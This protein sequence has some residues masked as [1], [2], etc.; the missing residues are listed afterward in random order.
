MMKRFYLVLISIF[1]FI[2]SLF[3]FNLRKVALE[4]VGSAVNS[5]FQ[6]SR[7]LV[8]IASNNGLS[9]YDGK[10]V[11]LIGGY[12]G[13]ENIYGNSEG[14]IFAETVYGLRVIN[15]RSNTVTP[16][17]MFNNV[18]FSAVDTK[19]TSFIIQGNTSMYYKYQAGKNY[20]NITI[21]GLNSMRIKLFFVDKIG[22]LRILSE[23]GILRSFELSYNSN[24]IDFEEKRAI[25]LPSR[26]TFS[27]TDEQ[28]LYFIDEKFG[29]SRFDFESNHSSYISDMKPL[30]AD[31]GKITSGIVFKN[32]FYFGTESGLFQIKNNNLVTI[33]VKAGVSRLVKDRYQDLIWI[34]TMGDGLYTYSS[35]PLTIKSYLFSDFYPKVSKAATAICL[36]KQGTLWIGTEGAGIV[37][38]PDFHPEREISEINILTKENGLPDNNVY[39]FHESSQGIWIGCESGLAFFS[40]KN[41]HVSSFDN[42]LLTDIQS[43][44]ENDSLLWMACYE[45]GIVKANITYRD[46]KPEIR[47]TQLYS[48]GNQDEASNRFTSIYADHRNILFTNTG[49]GIYKFVD[50]KL[51][52]IGLK[53][54]K[55]ESANQI[56]S[57][58]ESEY[59][60][61]TD[62]GCYKFV[63][64][65]KTIRNIQAL[66]EVATKDILPGN[67]GDY[68]LS[69]DN[70]L[71]LYNIAQN[72]IQYFSNSYGLTVSDYCNG[73]SFKDMQSGMLFFGGMNGFVVIQYNYYDE[74]MDYMPLLALEK[75]SLFGIYQNI[76]DFKRENSDKLVFEAEENVFSLTFNAIDY[77]NGNNYIYYYKIAD[78]QWIDN[79]NSGTISFTDISSG[80]YELYIKYYNKMLN[81]ESYTHMLTMTVLPPWYRSVY[82]YIAYFLL[83]LFSV[84]LSMHFILK[85]RRKKR[86]DEL[87]RAEQ[88]RVEDIYEAKLDF[89][90]D[91]A[92]EFCTPLTLISGPCSLILNQKGIAAPVQKYA[93][94]INRNAK[95]MNLLINDLMAFKQ[96]ESGFKLPEISRL[97]VSSILD[98]IVDAFK[99]NALGESIH[100]EK[101]YDEA[102]IWNSDEEFL[103][104]ILT[105]LISNAVKYSNDGS[106]SVEI[107]VENDVLVITVSN[108]GKGIAQEELGNI[109]NRFSILTS[110]KQKGWKQNGLG[111]AITGSMVRLLSGHI[112]VFS[113][114]NENTSFLVNLP[115]MEAKGIV[116]HRKNIKNDHDE[117]IIPEVVIPLAKYEHNENRATVTIIDDDP[118]MLWFICDTL[119]DEFNVLPVNDAS[120]ATG[121]LSQ[122]HTD[123]IVS[124]LMMG[125]MDGVELAKMLKSDKSTSHIPLIIVSAMHEIEMQTEVINAGAEMYI[126]KPFDPKNLKTT[127]RRL[128]GRKEDLK[129]YFTSPLSA[130]ELEMGKMQHGEHRK[131]LKKVYLIIS[132][133]IQNENLSPQFIASELG[134]SRRTLYRKVKEVTDKGLLE[135]IR[136]GRLTT[137]EN[138][139]LTSKSTIDEIVFKSGFSSR[140]SFYRAFANK[141]NCTPSE[142]IKKQGI[143]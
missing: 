105:N 131:F 132:K 6:D 109:F 13:V 108:R 142:F 18:S 44:Y 26:I 11:T 19:G 141:Y 43:V 114:P 32:E 85:R 102:V 52:R 96:M 138:L 78:G 59:M 28:Y 81:K 125:T 90:T 22:I 8:W 74:A 79:G 49:N 62:F 73:S 89:F 48:T 41:K 86:E 107:C 75:V 63:L 119:S 115:N 64:D 1:L 127:I 77:I 123:V 31:K 36:D 94:I 95:R 98:R 134:M 92:H 129:E 72:N 65:N 58:N 14:D 106:A 111:L 35:D 20:E 29:L 24:H 143:L 68:W 66:N 88:Q 10:E 25:Q 121:I 38:L 7:G 103:N 84:F 3:A 16:F 57:L 5:I 120:S 126:T 80:T 46:G 60:A 136:D 110:E 87:A 69:A 61:T 2:P 40:N 39:S 135:I 99:I 118:E 93:S 116:L 140:A 27:F 54:D 100:I 124:D 45:K 104:T 15:T 12:K 91:I 17:E 122:K 139:L 53:D 117:L 50:E 101:K 4:N 97:N 21:T 23:D 56:V 76:N 130:Y 113:T 51:D 37:L 55:F 83:S 30:L 133:N 137:A 9:T 67:W 70:G 33:H 71:F 42:A 112:E 47:H 128:L 82:A 34:S